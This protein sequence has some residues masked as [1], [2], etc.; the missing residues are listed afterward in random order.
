MLWRRRGLLHS[1]LFRLF[2]LLHLLLY[3]WRGRRTK[4]GKRNLDIFE[5]RHLL[6]LDG[7]D[8]LHRFRRRGLLYRLLHHLWRHFG[9]RLGLRW[10]LFNDRLGNRLRR[11][12]YGRRFFDRL[13]DVAFDLFRLDLVI[14]FDRFFGIDGLRQGRKLNHDRRLRRV[15]ALLF[16]LFLHQIIGACGMHRDHHQCRDGPE[17]DLSQA[18]LSGTRVDG[19]RHCVPPFGASEGWLDWLE[20]ETGAPAGAE[21]AVPSNPTS[22]IFR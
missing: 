14:G 3:W 7:I 18:G 6:L 15:I 5:L 20:L 9:G 16:R 21:P 13:G 2:F 8:L 11:R 4:H 22:A 17:R 12:F 19:V 1:L 10:W